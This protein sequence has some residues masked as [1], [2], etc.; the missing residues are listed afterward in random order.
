LGLGWLGPDKNSPYFDKL[1]KSGRVDNL[2]PLK[3]LGVRQV[4]VPGND[5]AGL[6]GHGALQDTVFRLMGHDLKPP[7]GIEG[8]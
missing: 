6:A 3:V 5:K 2:D 7:P 8:L 4:M 1:E